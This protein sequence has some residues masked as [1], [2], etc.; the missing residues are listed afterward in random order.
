MKLKRM[1]LLAL[2]LCMIV[3]LGACSGMNGTVP[4]QSPIGSSNKKVI[5]FKTD[6]PFYQSLDALYQKADFVIKAKVLDSRVEWMSH[7]LPRTAEYYA[8][9]NNPGGKQDDTKMITTIYTVEITASY[10]GKDGVKTMNIMQL[11]GED[12]SAIYV[13]EETPKL[14]KNTEY[15][16]FLSKSS[17]REN[18]GW[19]LNN[20][21][22]LYQVKG[23]DLM[24]IPGNTITINLDDMV[25]L[26]EAHKGV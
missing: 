8:N 11:G 19:L 25:K 26:M 22:S 21:Q 1:Q 5:A 4:G 15:V 3:L 14:A 24:S 2:S 12:E 23:N 13:C 18:A 10:K 9:P 7:V 16:L 6:Y 20:I 17:L